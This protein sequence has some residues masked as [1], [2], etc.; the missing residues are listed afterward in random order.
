MKTTWEMV[1]RHQLTCVHGCQANYLRAWVSVIR[2]QQ[3]KSCR[4]EICCNR[5]LKFTHGWAAK[6][7]VRDEHVPRWKQRC[8]NSYK[9]LEGFDRIGPYL[10]DTKT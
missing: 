2:Q 8:C 10:R 4:A 6:G 1:V 9:M 5:P 7:L 3:K